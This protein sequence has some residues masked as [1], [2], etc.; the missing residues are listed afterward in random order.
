MPSPFNISNNDTSIVL[1]KI[2]VCSPLSWEQGSNGLPDSVIATPLF[3]AVLF[4]PGS[5]TSFVPYSP[6]I[7]NYLQFMRWAIF[8]LLESAHAILS[9]LFFFLAEFSSVFRCQRWGYIFLPE[10]LSLT[11]QVWVTDTFRYLPSTLNNPFK[12]SWCIEIILVLFSSIMF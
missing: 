2:P 5:F 10:N 9:T 3:K 11:S 1:L 6:D 4:R 8:L 7:L 12:I